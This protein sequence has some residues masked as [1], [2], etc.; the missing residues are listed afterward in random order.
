MR[1]Q[2]GA[3]RRSRGRVIEAPEAER[4]RLGRDLNDGL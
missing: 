4:G 1:R 2:A 3:L